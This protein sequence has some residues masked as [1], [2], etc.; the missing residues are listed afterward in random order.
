MAARV[1]LSAILS[2]TLNRPLQ[3]V[4]SVDAFWLKNQIAESAHILRV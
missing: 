2:L 1:S 3:C 4:L